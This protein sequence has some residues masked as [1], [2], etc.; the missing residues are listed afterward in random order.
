MGDEKSLKAAR[1]YMRYA[2]GGGVAVLVGVV[3]LTMEA[4]PADFAE[5]GAADVAE[6]A[7]RSPLWR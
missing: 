3:W 7:A 6:F 5:G 2:L 4:G 1:L